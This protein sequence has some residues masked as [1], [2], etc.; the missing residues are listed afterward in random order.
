MKSVFSLLFVTSLAVLLTDAQG[1]DCNKAEIVDLATRCS[2]GLL[3]AL[4]PLPRMIG[5]TTDLW[6]AFHYI[7]NEYIKKAKLLF[8]PMSY[9]GIVS[10]TAMLAAY[11]KRKEA[12]EVFDM[13]PLRNLF[14]WTLMLVAHLLDTKLMFLESPETDMVS[15]TVVFEEMPKHDIVAWNATCAQN[16]FMELALATFS[17]MPERT[18][19][20]RQSRPTACF[21]E[22]QN[23]ASYARNSHVSEVIDVFHQMPARNIISW[24]TALG[25]LIQD[26]NLELASRML[27]QMPE[28]DLISVSQLLSTYAVNGHMLE[29][30]QV[31]FAANLARS[32]YLD[33]ARELIHTMPFFPGTLEW[34][35]LHS[36]RA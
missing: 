14:P 18:V 27:N 11:A 4:E 28:T 35:C 17:R 30:F 36:V 16:G 25:A 26:G 24:T 10:W 5:P 7:H 3:G 29:A 1:R 6:P 9:R 2:N 34:T 19:E 15:W 32:G 8:T 23:L 33:D 22:N 31:F 21:T 20:I 12:K 13:M